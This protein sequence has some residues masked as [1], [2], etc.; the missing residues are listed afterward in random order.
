VAVD[1][2]GGPD[3]PV[4]QEIGNELEMDT[5]AEQERRARVPGGRVE[6]AP[7]SLYQLPSVG[8]ALAS[9]A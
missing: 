3:A 9:L 6:G 2:G 5:L 8:E 4:A 7:F 1:V